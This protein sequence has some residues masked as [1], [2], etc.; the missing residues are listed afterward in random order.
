MSRILGDLEL[1][2]VN[3]PTLMRIRW[4]MSDIDDRSKVPWDPPKAAKLPI[5]YLKTLGDG[6]GSP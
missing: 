3:R 5:N 1:H 6:F 2:Y 4:R